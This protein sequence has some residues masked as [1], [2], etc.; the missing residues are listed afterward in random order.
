MSMNQQE[1]NI[2]ISNPERVLRILQRVAQGGLQILVRDVTQIET[3]VKGRAGSS[4]SVSRLNGFTISGLSE[5]GRVYLS[6][7]PDA[8]LQIEFVLMATKVIF[9]SKIMKVEGNSVMV[10]LPEVLTSIE[11]RKDARYAVTPNARAFV[12]IENWHPDQKDTTMAPFFEYQRENASL[13]GAGD[14]SNGGLSIVSR[15][16]SVC[17]ILQRGAV[18]EQSAL[19]LP[20]E[21]PIPTVLEVR[22]VKRIRDSVTDAQGN[23]RIIRIYKFGIQFINP[24]ERLQNEI[25]K[26]MAKLSVAEAI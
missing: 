4:A 24:N 1:E 9:H 11:R 22:W 14:V 3:A 16:P 17:R 23:M 10:M 18:L 20:L 13:L 6:A 15:F 7:H 2:K 8:V 26:F 12:K 5:R 21:A 25:Q 19:V